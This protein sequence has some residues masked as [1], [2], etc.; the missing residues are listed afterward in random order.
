MNIIIISK[1]IILVE[2]ALLEKYPNFKN[3]K[4]D[5]GSIKEDVIFQTI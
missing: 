2:L 5:A 1:K 3:L 4:F